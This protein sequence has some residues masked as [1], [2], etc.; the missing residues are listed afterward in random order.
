MSVGEAGSAHLQSGNGNG[1]GTT[2]RR[3]AGPGAAAVAAADA[4]TRHRRRNAKATAPGAVVATA[5]G[6]LDRSDAFQASL[7]GGTELSSRLSDMMSRGLVECVVCL[8]RVRRNSALWSC[9]TCFTI[10]HLACAKKWGRQKDDTSGATLGFRCP[11]CRA[12]DSPP[13]HFRCYCGKQ[14]NPPVQPG[15]VPGCCGEPCL[16]PKGHKTSRC[17]HSCAELCHPGPCMPCEQLGVSAACLCGKE[18]IPRRCGDVV[19]PEGV[20]CGR[21]CGQMLK[22]GHE[23]SDVCHRPGMCSDCVVSVDLACYCG[24]GKMQLPCAFAGEGYSCGKACGGLLACG[25]HRC[26]DACH[27]GDCQRCRLDPE[28][29]TTCPCGKKPLLET[30]ISA[31]ESCTDPIPSCG[32]KCGSRLGCLSDHKC[33]KVCGHEGS[34]GKCERLV[35]ALCRCGASSVRVSCGAD[36]E[37]LHKELVCASEC[38]DRRVCRKHKC[39]RICCKF[40]KRKVLVREGVVE[41]EKFFLGAAASRSRQEMAAWRRSGHACTEDCDRPLSCGLHNCDAACGHAEECA[42]CGL[43]IREPIACTCGASTVPPPARCGTAP[44][45]CNKPCS[46]P[47]DRCDH[48]CPD[49]CHSGPCPPCVVLLRKECVGEHGEARFVP[50]HVSV[51]GTCSHYFPRFLY[52]RT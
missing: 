25:V 38:G 34:C 9:A 2:A 26:D 12:D 21:G 46:R 10:V 31:R 6:D 30:E 3:G 29:V 39:T 8:D 37:T 52:Y 15:L 17:P 42:P 1:A 24:A 19:A 13:A 28:V 22:C 7:M 16:R 20:S 48:P 23:C 11:S 50:C 14:K 43:L 44:P 41:T 40:R 18:R 4:K 45:P 5:R 47:R 49:N 27:E 51:D 32:E 35:D 36:E 33:E